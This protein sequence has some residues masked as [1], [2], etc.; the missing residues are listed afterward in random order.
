MVAHPFRELSLKFKVMAVSVGLFA[1]AIW[2]LA[3]QISSTLREDMVEQLSKQQYSLASFVAER[4]D[5]A[6]KVRIES[7]SMIAGS[8]TPEMLHNG[9]ALTNFLEER[10][11]IYKLFPLGVIVIGKDGHGIADH[12]V[13]PNRGNADFTQLDFYQDAIKSGKPVVSKPSVGRFIKGP[14]LVISV[15]I[16][17]KDHQVEGVF[18]G[19]LSLFEDNPFQQIMKTDELGGNGILLISPRHGL[20]VSATEKSRILQPLPPSGINK[21]HDR[22][23]QGY[24]GSGIAVSSLGVEELSSARQIPSAGWFAVATMPT[25]EAFAPIRHMQAHIYWSSG[26]LSL[27]VCI[28]LWF[29]L[30][31]EFAPLSRMAD[32]LNQLSSADAPLQPLPL[33]GSQEMRLLQ[34][35]FN[36]LEAQLQEREIELQNRERIYRDMFEKNSAIKLL[37]DIE[38]GDIV[39]ANPAAAEFYGW[40]RDELRTMHISQINT[41]HDTELRKNLLSARTGAQH[42]FRF[43]HRLASG[44]TRLVEVHSG[45]LEYGGRTVLHSVILDVT[46]R[47]QAIRRERERTF[48][49]EQLSQGHS[50]EH[51]LHLIAQKAVI[52]VP[53]ACCDILLLE[54]GRI[55][56]PAQ[57]ELP[58]ALGDQLHGIAVRDNPL[59]A[60][61]TLM[62]GK[63]TVALDIESSAYPD[64]FKAALTRSGLRSELAEP[65]VSSQHNVLG[66]LDFYWPT[67]D[68]P[69]ED[70]LDSLKAFVEL[71]RI[72]I[73]QKRND[74]NLQLASTVFHSSLDAILITDPNNT[75]LAV[76]PSFTQITGY[77]AHEAVGQNPSILSSGKY[78]AEFYR[79]MWANIQK[80]GQWQGEITNRRKNGELF[81]EWLTINTVYDEQ[82]NVLR[83][84]GIFSDITEKKQTEELIWRQA[85]YDTLT[86]LPNR[87][88]FLDRLT[89]EIKRADRE[90]TPVTLMFID[91]DH[92]KEVND[93]LGHEAGDTL[94][95]EAAQ[96]ITRCIRET[97]T[98]ARLGGDEFTIIFPKMADSKRLEEVGDQIIETLSNPFMIENTPAY[99]SASIGITL[100]PQDADSLQELLRN[101]DQAMYVAK[102][103][104]RNRFSYFTQSMQREAQYRLQL[105]NDLRNALENN[106]FELHYQ[107]I[108]ELS[109][110]KVYKAEALLRWR[111][112]LRGYVSPAQ[113]IPIAEE[114]GLI[115]KIGGWAFREAAHKA[116]AWNDVMADQQCAIQ[117]SVNNS[118]RQFATGSANLDM[119]SYL[120]D[121]GLPPACIV[122]EITE[123]LLMDE[124]PE[125]TEKLL[126]FRDAGIQVALDDFGTGYS[127]MSYLQKFDIDYIK[128]DQSFVRDMVENPGDQA[129]AEAIIVMSHKLGIKV[130]AEGVETQ[131]QRDLLAAAGCDY[132]QGYYFARPMPGDQF[133]QYVKNTNACS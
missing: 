116:Q 33:E 80:T 105:S 3:Y 61:R 103:Q 24:E 83:R 12:P 119:V 109:S 72:T 50:L 130:I 132:V 41:L 58:K 99:V 11:A 40:S 23:M 90:D 22:Y 113:F 36:G 31:R 52:D 125:V 63:R 7:L 91:L 107:P 93:T 28:F 15:P 44:A 57:S 76:N 46:A 120:R 111:H 32:K 62:T 30:R 128:I 127:A 85:N 60:C 78:D 13:L 98:L 94:L 26:V 20:F 9:P 97:D 68:M 101:A 42:T 54:D 82:R 124:R 66:T 17:G 25:E 73:E 4:I 43:R 112:P 123:G 74:E 126:A 10:K 96:R 47:E 118:P 87:R 122:V 84:I 77:S 64:A 114:I 8:I 86:G 121:I 1:C 27:L 81:V 2:V 18:A 56:A 92:F 133:D 129:I 49:L 35:A 131:A 89:Q 115:N 34:T 16:F 88:L 29:F 53:G 79:A 5:D 95:K 67:N 59:P 39:D 108:I 71:A 6:L 19:V 37:I 117:I 69:D 106:E 104:G 38:T 75:I 100:Y 48:I 65:I 70:I 55:R 45:K 51:I 14:R 110:G 21:M 102:E